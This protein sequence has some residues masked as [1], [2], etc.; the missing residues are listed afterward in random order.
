[1]L[2][3]VSFIVHLLN[4]D[5]AVQAQTVLEQLWHLDNVLNYHQ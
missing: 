1:M 3:V 5:D 2:I 4:I